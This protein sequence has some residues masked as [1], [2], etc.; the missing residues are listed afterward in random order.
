MAAH[1]VQQTRQRALALIAKQDR[2]VA[3]VRR[4]LTRFADVAT[5]ET[6]IVDLV[7]M[8]LV[9][10]RAF[11]RRWIERRL[12]KPFGNG[13]FAEELS[14]KGVE[15]SIVTDILEEFGEQLESGWAA[16]N[17]LHRQA[18]RY[19]NLDEGKARRRMYGLLAR[20]GFD[21]DTTV[22][23]V[24]QVLKEIQQNEIQRD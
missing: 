9:D 15:E 6:V 1:K 21:N 2:T 4:H 24:D 8:R 10:D 22:E 17:L 18:H 3:E 7:R 11:A 13:K 14:K 23:A 12:G 16:V 19:S 5:V 20:R